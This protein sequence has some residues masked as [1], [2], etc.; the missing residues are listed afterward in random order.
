MTAHLQRGKIVFALRNKALKSKKNM[1]KINEIA[2]NTPML[3][4][5]IGSRDEQ[6]LYIKKIDEDFF[7]E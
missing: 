5:N 3:R 4:Y 1:V 2:L 6:T 7:E